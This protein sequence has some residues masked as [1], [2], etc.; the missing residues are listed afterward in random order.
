MMIAA[1]AVSGTLGILVLLGLLRRPSENDAHAL[2]RLYPIALPV[3]TASS[4][5]TLASGYTIWSALIAAATSLVALLV[6]AAIPAPDWPALLNRAP[7]ATALTWLSSV[8]VLVGFLVLFVEF[9]AGLVANVTNLNYKA[10]ALL[11]VAAGVCTGVG[12]GGQVGRS[13]FVIVTVSVAAVLSAA[14]GVIAGSASSLTDPAINIGDPGWAGNIAFPIAVILAA[15]LLPGLRGS[16]SGG[17][18]ATVVP[19]VVMA[20]TL[21][22]L[23]TGLLMVVGGAIELPSVQLNAIIAFL[24]LGIDVLVAVILAV[25]VVT[26]VAAGTRLAIQSVDEIRPSLPREG[27]GPMIRIWSAVVL[28]VVVAVLAISRPA[29]VTVIVILA[30][31]AVIGLASHRSARRRRLRP[32]DRVPDPVP[33]V[34]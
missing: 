13:R 19:A 28:A 18:R 17:A 6:A 31:T 25:L 4:A 33:Q 15:T 21:L 11:V 10:V 7:A 32:R 14:G 20:A 8:A 30:L 16:G 34:P 22:V 24:P 26:V 23:M 27:G 5:A 2:T 1:I 3:F 29:P 12:G 9:G